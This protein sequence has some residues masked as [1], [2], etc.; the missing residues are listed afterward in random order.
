MLKINTNKKSYKTVKKFLLPLILIII[1]LMLLIQTVL[2][3]AG[4]DFWGT[5]YSDGTYEYEY[6]F[7]H[8]YDN[9]N[10]SPYNLYT[11]PI[12][13]NYTWTDSDE[14]I[15]YR[16]RS[17]SNHYGDSRG[18]NYWKTEWQN[19]DNINKYRGTSGNGSYGYSEYTSNSYDPLYQYGAPEGGGIQD[20]G[21]KIY[22]GN[23]TWN[24]YRRA[25][26]KL[27]YRA[28]PTPIHG[29]QYITGGDTNYY[30]DGSTLWV[31][32]DKWFL[33]RSWA[34]DLYPNSYGQQAQYAGNVRSTTFLMHSD[35]WDFAVARQIDHKYSSTSVYSG[36]DT[37]PSTVISSGTYWRGYE[38][39]AREVYDGLYRNGN[40]G[41]MELR[42]PNKLSLSMKTDHLNKQGRW[43]SNSTAGWNPTFYGPSGAESTKLNTD[44]DAPTISNAYIENVTN[45]SFDVVITGIS[46]NGG[47]GVDHVK[48]PV[49]SE[50]NGQDDLIWHV[51]STSGGTVRFNVNTSNHNMEPG[52]EYNIRI[53]TDDKLYNEG[54]DLAALTVRVGGPDLTVSNSIVNLAND[55]VV[56][57]IVEGQQYRVKNVVKNIGVLEAATN[58]LMIK[59]SLNRIIGSPTISTI[60]AGSEATYYSTFTA[61]NTLGR[62]SVT[63]IV[64]NTNIID[65][66]NENN[67][68]STTNATVYFYNSKPSVAITGTTPV[69][70]GTSPNI[71]K[72]YDLGFDDVGDEITATEWAYSS[73][74]KANTDATKSW[75]MA[76]ETIPNS[77]KDLLATNEKFKTYN[78][79]V[80]I[81]D[82]GNPYSPALWSDYAYKDIVVYNINTKPTS[83]F[84]IN[85]NV[86]ENGDIGFVDLSSAVDTWDKIKTR[87]YSIDGGA[88]WTTT[89]PTVL[90]LEG[91]P[92]NQNSKDFNIGFSVDDEGH[93]YSPSLT[94]NS[95]FKTVRVYRNNKKPVALFTVTPTIAKINGT[96]SYSDN[97]YDPDPWGIITERIWEYRKVKDINGN[98]IIDAWKF[99]KPTSFTDNGYFEIRLK[100]KDNGNGILAP[101]WSDYYTQTVKISKSDLIIK[102]MKI[103]N[104]N[105]NN[106]ATYLLQ[107]NNYR[108]KA[109]VQNIG[110]VSS[111]GNIIRFS[112]SSNIELSRADVPALAASQETSIIIE[113]TQEASGSSYVL[114]GKVDYE[115][116]VRELR[117]DNNT[118]SLTKNL[119]IKDLVT[120]NIIIKDDSGNTVNSMIQGHSYSANVTNKNSG[121]IAITE[122][123][124][125]GLKINSVLQNSKKS[126]TGG[127]LVGAS[128]AEGNWTLTPPVNTSTYQAYKFDGIADVDNTVWET[129]ENNNIKTT[130]L[131]AYYQNLKPTLIDIVGESD[132]ISVTELQ[133]GKK[134]RV[135]FVI[136]NDGQTNIGNFS[137]NVKETISN[138]SIGTVNYSGLNANTSTSTH[139]MTFTSNGRCNVNFEVFADSGLVIKE[140]NEADNK[141]ATSRSGYRLNLKTTKI[142]IIGISDTNS[143]N[144]LTQNIQYRAAITVQN[145]GDKDISDTVVALY[146][147]A[148]NTLSGA[149]KHGTTNLTLAKGASKIVYINFTPTNR[150]SR[151]FLGVAD[152][153]NIVDETDELDNTAYTT[154]TIN[155]VNIK[156]VVMSIKDLEGNSQ[157]MIQKGGNY[158]AEV[159]LI[160]DGD[161]DIG[162]FNLGF[163]DNDNKIASLPIASLNKS[164]TPTTFVIS[165]SPQNG[166]SRTFKAFADDELK[167]EE[168]IETD[169]QLSSVH[170]V[171]IIQLVNYR[172]TSIVN[173]PKNYT[174]PLD[175]SKMPVEVKAGYNVTFQVDVIGIA[176]TVTADFSGSSN[177]NNIPVS[178][179]KVEDITPF[180]SVWE[181]TIYTDM[182]TPSGTIIYSTLI[183]KREAEVYNY[184][185]SNNFNGKTLLTN[186]SALEDFDINRIY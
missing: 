24:R 158:K 121:T 120:D 75:S 56:T 138:S 45:N 38:Y 43:T 177:L 150:G 12:P 61:P 88:T 78:T 106:E 1:I 42:L 13:D 140:S 5:F 123:F 21:A 62:Y 95:V 151:S 168:S 161:I 142:D 116:L 54:R 34:Y 144:P 118:A 47:V 58:Q 44:G 180:H 114:N 170:S 31:Q 2:A 135:K 113:Y 89:K 186:G 155:K 172:I 164:T 82:K 102:E 169:N 149:N 108:I 101:L 178:F 72:T 97:S 125:I 81:K 174:Y 105:D 86:S 29:K 55:T 141:L 19:Y 28:L 173:P 11:E 92:S 171:N 85:P 156:A 65:E 79:R 48:I 63:S 182:N 70:K 165:F 74:G 10:G 53:Y 90:S 145:D 129:Y 131:N 148:S 9:G 20:G 133:Q 122:N 175:T 98:P 22:W 134:Y 77:I 128:S 51:A 15:N 119:Y 160:N 52:G 166:G 25:A 23:N 104:S 32:P 124:N 136:K 26:I 100:V 8:Y 117:E 33:W 59:D 76:S 49:W 17:K 111:E 99:G 40:G 159:Q 27:Y 60:A 127:L 4:E 162:A 16:D 30:Q 107:G 68:T 93:T 87:R 147:N 110:E 132:D 184:N 14:R 64:D 83:N 7:M 157:T 18:W 84:N 80:R 112:N 46:D 96:L 176:D 91:L 143:K 181:A 41:Q 152:D 50:K 94:S 37:N 139:Y 35:G 103:L 146:E 154:R 115:D 66:L 73:D 183:G 69:P 71:D 185:T 167:I 67:N 153:S 137:A 130:T 179:K 3:E 109:I 57:N 6:G 39:G 36:R 163:Y 126:I